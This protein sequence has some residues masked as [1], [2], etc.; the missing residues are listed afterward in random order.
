MDQEVEHEVALSPEK[1][2]NDRRKERDDRRKRLYAEEISYG[3]GTESEKSLDIMLE[4]QNK[5]RTIERK[6]VIVY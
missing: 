6:V 2:R 1:I 3:S 5:E 4:Y